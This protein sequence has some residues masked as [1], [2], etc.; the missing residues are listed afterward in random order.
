MPSR[1]MPRRIQDRRQVCVAIFSGAT[2]DDLA[3]VVAVIDDTEGG[4]IQ[5]AYDF[6]RNHWRGNP[7]D[8]HYVVAEH[9]TI[10]LP[11]RRKR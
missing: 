4:A 9:G 8:F 5:Q 11:L 3:G 1:P 2:A 7:S 6:V 10:R